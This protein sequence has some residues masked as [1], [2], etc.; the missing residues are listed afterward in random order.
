L[1]A[2]IS[3]KEIEVATFDTFA[4]SGRQPLLVDDYAFLGASATTLKVGGGADELTFAYTGYEAN[5]YPRGD[6]GAVTGPPATTSWDTSTNSSS[7][8]PHT[9]LNV[10]AAPP[11]TTN[12]AAAA[13]SYYIKF[14]SSNGTVL[15]DDGGSS[16]I[17]ITSPFFDLSKLTTGKVSFGDLKFSLPS[18]S[19]NATLQHDLFS[20]VLLK[21]IEIATYTQGPNPALVDD[22]TFGT[23]A[24]TGANVIM[25]AT[26][27]APDSYSFVYGQIQDFHETSGLN[28]GTTI[29]GWDA[30]KNHADTSLPHTAST[31]PPPCY[32]PGTLILT[33]KGEITVEDLK[34]G[35]RVMTVSGEAKPI[36]WIGRRSYSGR[37]ALGQRDILPVC[38]KAEAIDENV[39]RRDLWISPHH[40]M[41][42]EGVLIEAKDLVN[43][44]SIVQAERVEKVEYFHIELDRHDVIIAEGALSES[45]VDD[46]NRGL[47]HNAHE[48]RAL[49]PDAPQVAA[50][51]CAARLEEGYEVEA[52]RQ[53]IDVRAGLRAAADAPA[54]DL[55]GYVDVA[56]R[57][58]IAGWAQAIGHPEA[59]VCLDIFAGGRLIGRTLANRYRED[60]AQAGLGSGRHGFEFTPPAGLAFAPHA[61]EVCRSLDG[62]ALDFSCVAQVARERVRAR[63]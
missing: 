40:A 16:W 56:S 41:Y 51:Y 22:Y 34:I 11:A 23:V 57:R 63:R 13:L 54:L 19:S 5:H 27:P 49:F 4:N 29:A 10:N 12:S 21:N 53:Q 39:P 25:A 36:K 35:D 15:K 3:I 50:R 58:R 32:C 24:A 43:G 59:P 48:Y 37:F 33:D 42:L 9:T 38:I 45:F 55:R 17:K 18:D 26:D 52:A 47:F 30:L 60:L 2:G 61:V 31:Q 14:T 8:P 7:V 6:T 1:A 28:G 20:G 46:D 44:V 62:A